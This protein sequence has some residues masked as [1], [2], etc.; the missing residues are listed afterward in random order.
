VVRQTS[1]LVSSSLASSTFVYSL[2][3][4]LLTISFQTMASP[5]ASIDRSVIAVND[6]LTFTI[7]LNG[8]GS[9]RGPDLV[10]LNQNFHVLGNSQSSR[11]MIRNGH[12]ESW[13][14]WVITLM[15]KREG[16]LTIP[17]IN[18]DGQITEPISINVQPSVPGSLDNLQP[19]FLESEVDKSSVYTQQQ[20]I[21][22]VRIFQSI[23]LNNIPSQ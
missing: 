4:L 21:Y 14:E 17:A 6:T 7:R 15:P 3:I 5:I 1:S 18:I 9:F 8:G 2:F 11:H 19:I 10:P 22:T 23:Q 13:T 20:V 16:R 12:S